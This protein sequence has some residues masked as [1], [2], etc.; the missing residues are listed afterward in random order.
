MSGGTGAPAV[1]EAVAAA[2]V[3]AIPDA[4]VVIDD[5]GQVRYVNRAFGDLFGHDPGDVLGGSVTAIIPEGLRGRHEQAME[6]YVETGARRIDWSWVEFPAL[7]ADGHEFPASVSLSEV[8]VEGERLFAGIIRDITDRVEAEAALRRNERL[9]RTL[10]ENVDAA[11]WVYDIR[12]G[13]Y[14]YASPQFEELWGRPR[15]Y[16]YELEELSAL[17][18]TVHE[19]DRDAMATVIDRVE[20]AVASGEGAVDG[21]ATDREYRVVQPDDTVRWVRDSSVIV[22]DEDGP[23]RL[24]GVVTDVTEYK[25]REEQLRADNARLDEFASVVSHDLRNPL[26]VAVGRLELA[27]ESHPD[28]EHLA[29][30]ADALDRIDHI[31]GGMLDT[32]RAG[33]DAADEFEELSLE[34]VARDAWDAAGVDGSLVVEDDRTLFGD[35]IRLGQLF[36]NLFVNA[37]EHAGPEPT[38]W[39]RPLDGGGFAVA[40]DGPGIPADECDDVFEMGYSGGGGTGFGLAIVRRI[41]AAHG[42]EPSVTERDGGGTE[43]AF[44][45]A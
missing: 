3:A 13:E 12:D 16:L 37:G 23:A 22:E 24:V 27:R 40:D 29:A 11:V 32:L 7:H 8:T 17:L 28:D 5:R 25:H 43:F 33:Q 41:A 45:P 21:T 20:A 35:R 39:V 30:A 9:F 10:A 4:V 18:E 36:Q 44:E 42:L 6:R 1:T 38:V 34:A 2:L 31:V 19:A 14:V 26:S 15:S